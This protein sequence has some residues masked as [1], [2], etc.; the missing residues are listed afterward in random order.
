MHSKHKDSGQDCL[1]CLGTVRRPRRAVGD[2]LKEQV[3]GWV[4][5]DPR[6]VLSEMGR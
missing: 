4:L 1:V 3:A 5:V 6:V 2:E